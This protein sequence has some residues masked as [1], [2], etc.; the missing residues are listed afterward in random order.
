MSLRQ[1]AT[2]LLE[3]PA[4][5]GPE[6]MSARPPAQ[7]T[8]PR[9]S[10]TSTRE[11]AASH[12][13]QRAWASTPLKKRLAVLR[14]ARHRIAAQAESFA[15][16]IS[17]DL[18]RTTADTLVAE[19]LPLLD[20]CRFL[21]RE[22]TRLL[23]PKKFGHRGRPF[24]L[25]G[26]FAEVHREPL[27]RVLIIGPGNFPLF[28]PGVQALQALAAGNVVIWKPG[29]GGE[30]VASLFAQVFK[31]AGLPNEVLR[32]TGEAVK[33]AIGMIDSAP[34]KV[35]FTGASST[36]REILRQLAPKLIPA[37]LELSGIDAV[38]V[39]PSADMQR[40]AK[41]VAFGLRLNG[42]QVC[43]SPRRLIATRETLALLHPHLVQELGA[44]PPVALS[45]SAA[46]RLRAALDA[47]RLEG[48]RVEGEF[49]PH[50]QRPLLVR[51]AHPG[52][53]LAHEA[54]F[55]PV[56]ALLQAET[57]GA[58]PALHNQTP[59]ALTCSIFGEEATARTL[60]SELRAGSVLINDLIAPTADPRLPFG[61]RGES[62]YGVTRGAEGLLAMTVP[63]VVQVRRN[64][65]VRHYAA[66]S[67]AEASLFA[68]TIRAAHAAGWRARLR[69]VGDVVRSARSR[70][71]S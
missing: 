71:S 5:A 40:A 2:N 28:L 21:E 24:W 6:R 39:L 34:D 13:A 50:A 59:F 27:G 47:A 57:E 61:G 43:M 37:V 36:G 32:V 38:I 23:L 60:V 45:A 63:K 49:S 68:G 52:M 64:R 35:V 26:V 14:A 22:A 66:T 42:G 19:V 3:T 69:A 70:R 67:D 12:A 7:I 11:P 18:Q 16:A 15:A 65:S 54:F 44:V 53:S 10:G 51:D 48:A 25:A 4:V 9:R 55:A 31:E 30:P 56:L 33:D 41:A 20:A 29:V 58:I 1:S 62:G 17:P 8:E 46:E